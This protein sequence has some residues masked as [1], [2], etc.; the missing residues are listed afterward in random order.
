MGS[1]ILGRIGHWGFLLALSGIVRGW[2][3]H[4]PCCGDARAAPRRGPHGEGLRPPAHGPMSEPF[5]RQI[6][7]PLLGHRVPAAWPDIL[8]TT[9]RET[10]SQRHSAKL[11]PDPLPAENG[12]RV[13]V[14]YLKL[15]NFRIFWY[16]AIDK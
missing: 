11:P 16:T 4:L 12:G 5:G 8:T 1:L 9:L 7:Q 6:P 14:C 10:L 15:L 13:H 3:S 2:G